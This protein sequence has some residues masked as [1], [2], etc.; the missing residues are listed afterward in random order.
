[1]KHLRERVL[2]RVIAADIM[3]PGEDST[4]LLEA[5]T[6]LDEHMVD[7]L[8][9]AGVDEILVRSAITC[10]ADYGVCAACYGRDLARGHIINIGEAVGVMAAQSIG[11]P[12]TQLT[13]RTFHIGG[14]A[15]RSAAASSVES[16]SKGSV[17]LH[18][19]KEI[20][21][22][23]GKL[24]AVSRSAELAVVDEAGRERERYKVPYGAVI[25]AKEGEA[26]EAGAI[27]ATWDPHTHPVITEVAGFATFSDFVSGVTTKEETDPT[28]GL[29]DKIIT[30]HKQRGGTN[31]DLRPM[32]KL[33]DKDGKRPEL[34]GYGNSGSLLPAT[35]CDH[36]SAG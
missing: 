11:E 32:I 6:L 31:K 27:L 2:G 23:D 24:M 19:M 1:M 8:E 13:M 35:R 26:I 20:T 15:S 17:R 14:A 28:T 12:G 25:Q 34:R 4:V 7:M 36:Q 18:N 10:E 9:E 22:K 29:T 3:K 33:V 30:D 21:N 16:K 5:G